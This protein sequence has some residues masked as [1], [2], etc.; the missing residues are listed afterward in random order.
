MN[1]KVDLNFFHCGK[2]GHWAGEFPETEAKQCGQLH[3]NI[4]SD[5]EKEDKDGSIIGVNFLRNIRRPRP[6]TR[7]I[8]KHIYL[9]RCSTYNKLMG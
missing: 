5:E 3:T 2:Q 9:D 4:V 8:P 1:R 7:Y 6:R